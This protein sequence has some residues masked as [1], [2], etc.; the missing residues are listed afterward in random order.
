MIV[1]D[2]NAA[3]CVVLGLVIDLDPHSSEDVE[4]I[5]VRHVIGSADDAAAQP[6]DHDATTGLRHPSLKRDLFHLRHRSA[7]NSSSRSAKTIRSIR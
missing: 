3:V 4:W 2:D 6:V 7:I 1:E 5:E